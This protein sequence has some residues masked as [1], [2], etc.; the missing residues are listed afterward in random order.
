M[1]FSLPTPHPCFA[2]FFSPPPPLPDSPLAISTRYGV[3]NAVLCHLAH[4]VLSSASPL[5]SLASSS[6]SDIA[7]TVAVLFSWLSW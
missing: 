5:L 3:E 2:V 6:S 1:R 7:A 4:S